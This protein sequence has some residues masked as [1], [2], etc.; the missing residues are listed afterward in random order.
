MGYWNTPQLPEGWKCEGG[1]EACIFCGR[2]ASTRDAKGQ[3][4]HVRCLPPKKDVQ[5]ES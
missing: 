3:P 4:A 5:R 2:G 1:I